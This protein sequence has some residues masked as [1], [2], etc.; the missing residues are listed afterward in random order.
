M[1]LVPSTMGERFEKYLLDANLGTMLIN[2]SVANSY[3]QYL[4]YDTTVLKSSWPFPYLKPYFRSCQYCTLKISIIQ[5]ISFFVPRAR[6][7]EA[8]KIITLIKKLRHEIQSEDWG[9]FF[10]YIPKLISESPDGAARIHSN[11]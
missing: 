9:T 7:F 5:K 3:R 2:D 4:I 6:A 11:P 10:C 8:D 1:R